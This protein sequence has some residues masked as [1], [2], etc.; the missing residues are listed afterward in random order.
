MS[1]RHHAGRV[2]ASPTD[3]FARPG[4]RKRVEFPTTP[5][6]T[7][8]VTSPSDFDH[9]RRGLFTSDVATY[10]VGRPGYPDRVYE[11]LRQ[12]CGLGAGTRVLEMGP[13]TGQATGRLLDLGADVTVIELGPELAD[14]LRRRFD[15]RAL[16][17]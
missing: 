1:C 5:G 3:R 15:G 12:R 10:A 6:E 13:G 4:V 2:R 17:V 7:P 11:L 9:A 8:E 14:H 16:A